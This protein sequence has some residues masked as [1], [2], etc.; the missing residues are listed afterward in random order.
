[1]KP[2]TARDFLNAIREHSSVP[3]NASCPTCG[4]WLIYRQGRLSI[5][6]TD[7]GVTISLGFCEACDGLPATQAPVH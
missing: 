7:E 3:R 4:A 1:M 2:Y 5:Y 6:G